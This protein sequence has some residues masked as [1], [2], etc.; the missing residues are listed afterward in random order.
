[1]A[2]KKTA[3]NNTANY[4]VDIIDCSKSDLT[5]KERIQL[6][7]MSDAVKLDKA[8]RDSEI[9]ID[10][11]FYA[12]AQIHNENSD[13]KDYNTYIIVSKDGTRYTTGSSTFWSSFMNIYSEMVN[14]DE[15]WQL[16]VYQ[17]PSR[18]REGKNFIT[19][20]VV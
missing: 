20:S 10:V 6:K 9:L 15:D 19:C 13:D 16:K 7:D 18:Q 11:D 12:I 1:M 2:T 4:K 14:T 8:T 17:L 5:G 3:E